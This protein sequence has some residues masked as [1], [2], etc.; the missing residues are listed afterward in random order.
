MYLCAGG[1]D[2]AQ[3]RL[4]ALDVN[5][6]IIVNEKDGNL[7]FFSAGTRLQQEEFI[8]HALGG[9]Q[10]NGDAEKSGYR[11]ELAAIRTTASRLHRDNAKCSP[12]LPDPVE[13]QARSLRHQ[14]E[15]V[16]I[17]RLPWDYGIGLE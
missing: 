16:E 11:A 8:H 3:Q 9:A 6:E 12:A 14:I 13:Q 5:G 17:D 4:G 15:L 2:V 10:A 7:P 1:N